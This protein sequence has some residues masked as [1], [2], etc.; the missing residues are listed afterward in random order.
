MKTND[1]AGRKVFINLCGSDKVAA[2]GNWVGGVIPDEV[3]EA[4]DNT[5]DLSEQQQ[6]MLRF[7]LALGPAQ[8]GAQHF[9][10]S[11]PGGCPVSKVWPC[12]QS[13]LRYQE[14]VWRFG[15]SQT[16]PQENR[17]VKPHAC[18]GNSNHRC[19]AS[20]H[21]RKATPGACA[22]LPVNSV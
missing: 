7:P 9:D 20:C 10:V 13:I 18:T 5:A 1:A 3:L 12:S 22:S 17:E 6:N 11:S 8:V 16:Q 19:A 14:Q 15:G 21:L 4:L 2:P